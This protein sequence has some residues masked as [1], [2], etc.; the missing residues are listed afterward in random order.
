MYLDIKNSI[1]QKQIPDAKKRAIEE[2]R[3]EADKTDHLLW[4]DEELE[5]E[6]TVDF[7]PEKGIIKVSED[8][9]LGYLSTSVA[10]DLELEIKILEHVAKAV[11][12]MKAALESVK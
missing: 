12:R 1:L 8:T 7:D 3:N 10:L 4:T 2:F 9:D 6:Q 11:N 5:G